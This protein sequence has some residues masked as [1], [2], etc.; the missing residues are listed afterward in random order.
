MN[1]ILEKNQ[2]LCEE[3]EDVKPVGG[4]GWQ[5]LA[6]K[7]NALLSL[8]SLA[9]PPP[10]FPTETAHPPSCQRSEASQWPSTSGR[11]PGVSL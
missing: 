1:A 8:H 3:L 11:Q 6:G 4:E 10:S 5:L 7:A 2:Q 9:E